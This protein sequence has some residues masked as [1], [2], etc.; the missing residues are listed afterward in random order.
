LRIVVRCQDAR[1]ARAAQEALACAGI[2]AMAQPGAPAA[3]SALPENAD[4][5]V[6]AESDAVASDAFAKAARIGQRSPVTVLRALASDAPPPA[7][8]EA[9]A[10]FDGA[11]ALDAAPGLL[12]A[13]I[14]ASV[15][16]GIAEEELSRR[17]ATAT[18]LGAPS[19]VALA[20]R[21]LKAIY[22]GAPSPVFLSLEA[23]F[24]RH[25]GLV[26]AAFSSFAG[27][28]HLHD[29][30]F[31]AVVLNGAQDPATAISLCAAL[32]RN[33]SLNHLPTLMVTAPGDH[34]TR[35]S[36]IERG[37]AAIVSVN[38]PAGPSLGWLFEAIR[39]ERRRIAAEHEV[40]GLR[41]VM[42]DPRTGL[43]LRAPFNAHLARLAGDHHASGR[44]LSVAALRVMPA[45]G[46]RQPPEQVWARGFAEIANL[47]GRLM[48]DTDCGVAL[49][50]EFV[51][52]ALPAT[53]LS[54]AKRTAERVASVAE[55]T[56]FA[57]GDGGAG[58]LVF[59][60]SVA[61]LQP[62]ESGGALLARALRVF[63]DDARARAN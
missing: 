11:I 15:R 54:G 29:E 55:C 52:L 24:G 60:Q 14:A 39:R 25:N 45:H 10:L 61:E 1:A 9:P 30:C 47:A 43:F 56:A 62:G 38:A 22:I 36:A 27:F 41:D 44:A 13:Q 58:P 19:P 51:V 63:E 5:V 50:A 17:R 37:A 21:K 18:A 34:A 12:T 23:A 7:G 3:G 8:L 40:R 49:G 26:A 6:V 48:R 53:S 46:A 28:D 31:D 20:P 59:E 57:S 4:V 35:K 42:A 16:A 32:R 33:G 2:E